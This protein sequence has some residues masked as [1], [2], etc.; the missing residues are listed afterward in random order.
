MDAEEIQV[1]FKQPRASLPTSHRKLS[2]LKPK[3]DGRTH[4]VSTAGMGAPRGMTRAKAAAGTV[5][6]G[7]TTRR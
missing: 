2:A 4:A 7:K 5:R 1:N 6:T 3:I